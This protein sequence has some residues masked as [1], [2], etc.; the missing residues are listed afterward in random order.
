M[1]KKSYAK[2]NEYIWGKVLNGE[3]KLGDQLP[4]E[5]EFAKILNISRNSVREGIRV[6]E[7]VGVVSSQQGAGNFISAE[8]EETLVEIMS[9]MYTLNGMNDNQ[10][11]EFRYAIEWEA[12]NLITGK[13]SEDIKEAL[14]YYLEKLE[15]AESEE[16]AVIYDKSIHYYLIEATNN[17]YMKTNYRALNKVMNL[18]IPRLRGKIIVG[19]KGDKELRNAHRLLVEGVVEGDMKKSMMGLE[20]HFRYIIE[21]Q[22]S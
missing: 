13:V 3:L 12:V 19:M 21:Y 20:Q 18:Y 7:N 8:F 9:F 11:T 4:P 17:D 16:E 5:R 22:N 14:L 2:V 10:I 1:Q 6:L 15:Q